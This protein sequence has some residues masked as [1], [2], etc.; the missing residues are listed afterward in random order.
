LSKSPGGNVIVVVVV[1]TVVEVVVGP[2]G[3][4]SGTGAPTAA[5]KQSSASVALTG[6]VPLGAHTHSGWHTSVPTAAFKMNR[7]SLAV[8]L[9]PVDSG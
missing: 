9:A 6:S 4:L 3:Q 5:F 1:E 7:Q 2:H 8:G